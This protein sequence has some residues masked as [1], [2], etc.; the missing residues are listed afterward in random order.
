[1]NGKQNSRKNTNQSIPNKKERLS[2]TLPSLVGN[3]E[4]SLNKQSTELSRARGR[5][6][7]IKIKR[8]FYS[9]SMS[10]TPELGSQLK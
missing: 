2:Y 8:E 7:G 5:N 1:M 6:E 4:S 10:N 9:S 3:T